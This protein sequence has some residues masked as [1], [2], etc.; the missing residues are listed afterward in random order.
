M[1]ERSHELK[2][3]DSVVWKDDV[4]VSGPEYGERR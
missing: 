3:I 1:E 2:P 4:R